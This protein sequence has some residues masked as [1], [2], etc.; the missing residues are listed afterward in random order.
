VRK[1]GEVMTFEEVYKEIESKGG[2]FSDTDVEKSLS[3]IKKACER[4]T[5]VICFGASQIGQKY[6]EVLRYY[7]F[8]DL[9]F[10]D[11][12]KTGREGLTSVDILSPG[13]LLPDYKDSAFIISVGDSFYSEIYNQLTGL[14]I[15]PE[16]IIP[17]TAIEALKNSYFKK[18]HFEGYRWA[19]DY[20]T[21]DVSRKTIIS[22][23]DWFL[24][25][26]KM[27]PVIEPNGDYFNPDYVTL[28]ENEVFI[29]AGGFNGDS[30]IDF[31]K[32][33]HN[34]YNA[35]Y[36]FECDKSNFKN[37]TDNL[38]NYKNINLINSALWSEKTKLRFNEGIK[39][40]SSLSTV[41]NT[42]VD[43]VSLDDL[44]IGKSSDEFPTF[45][46][47][48]IEG[49]EKEALLGAETVIK[50]TKPK[51][52]ISA[53]HKTQDFYVLPQLILKMRS[54]YTLHLVHDRDNCY[55]TLLFGK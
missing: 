40:S 3:L 38:R 17:Q 37:A 48:D 51:L 5:G 2:I 7:G 15:S 22:K 18:E 4:G 47:M 54:D 26:K 42:I 6:V 35:V 32:T 8:N 21:D 9:L 31:I 41:G 30:A 13:E 20:F 39:R 14:G 23:I 50:T 34:K 29:D 52:A 1:N 45:I 27:E 11:N 16:K 12:I 49:A 24:S 55:E 46:K 10:C 36:L 53:Y 44:F 25:D 28:T 33:V 43:A 19:Y